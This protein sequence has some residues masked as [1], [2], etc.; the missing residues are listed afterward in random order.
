[1]HLQKLPAEARVTLATLHNASTNDYITAADRVVVEIPTNPARVSSNNAASSSTVFS[2]LLLS[3]KLQQ[4]EVV[5]APPP[6]LVSET[7]PLLQVI[8]RSSG[9]KFLVDAGAS[10]LMWTF[11]VA[12]V[13]QLILGYDF[14]KFHKLSVDPVRH[15]L[16]HQPSNRI[17]R[18]VN[19]E[20]DSPRIMGLTIDPTYDT[21][22]Q[23]FRS[24]TKPATDATTPVDSPVYHYIETT[25]P[26]V[27]SRPRRLDPGK[28]QAAKQKFNS[29]LQRGIVRPS[30]SCWASPFHMV[31]KQAVGE[32][33]P[34]G[35]YRAAV[36]E[37]LQCSPAELVYG[38][39]L[40]LPGEF[41]GDLVKDSIVGENE[42]LDTLRST[43]S[44]FL[45]SPPRT[46]GNQQCF[47]P[48]ALGSAEY[49]WVRHD[50]HRRPLQR[51]YN[52]PFKVISK[53]SKYFT[54]QGPRREETVTIDRLKPAIVPLTTNDGGPVGSS[55]TPGEIYISIPS[56]PP[57]PA[58]ELPHSSTSTDLK[59]DPLKIEPLVASPLKAESD[60]SFSDSAGAAQCPQE[61]TTRSG[62]V[63]R[64]PDRYTSM[65]SLCP[66]LT[67]RLG[68]GYCGASKPPQRQFTYTKPPKQQFTHTRPPQHTELPQRQFT[69]FKRAHQLVHSKSCE[70]N[71][72]SEAS[73]QKYIS[74]GNLEKGREQHTPPLQP[75]LSLDR[76]PSRPPD[77]PLCH[78]GKFNRS[79]SL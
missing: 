3:G 10:L 30:S 61:V 73:T 37:D 35:D 19:V 58:P 28:L 67:T 9:S 52:G 48:S 20:I 38:E 5:K 71:R 24:L 32:W 25:G 76:P 72:A 70:T 23:E 77:K 45:A 47:V 55:Q 62:R 57:S 15:C 56:P 18:S 68:G 50:G 4:R 53:S 1:M 51:P 13:T 31:P 26:P 6:A 33:R 36:K 49:V 22:L 46:P 44:K 43:V 41:C 64:P 75:V 54:I 8:D 11:V 16:L 12:E 40:R 29:L 74:A 27:F 60:I 59:T 42:F 63:S 2:T 69:G 79:T 17:I 66:A 7:T 39:S 78:C 65:V 21:I 34:C 14:L